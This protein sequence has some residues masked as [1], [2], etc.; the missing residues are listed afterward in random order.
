MLQG[1]YAYPWV[2]S[3]C[4]QYFDMVDPKQVEGA[5]IKASMRSGNI[6]AFFDYAA[7]LYRAGNIDAALSVLGQRR[8]EGQR[9]GRER[10]AA[11]VSARGG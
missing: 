6:P 2:G 3:H 4:A 1:H 10:S 8:P 9:L 11:R 7:Y 5:L